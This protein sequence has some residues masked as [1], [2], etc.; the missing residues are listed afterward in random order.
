[1]NIITR[2]SDNTR[3]YFEHG[4]ITFKISWKIYKNE[5]CVMTHPCHKAATKWE[6]DMEIL[7]K[8]YYNT[9]VFE[10]QSISGSEVR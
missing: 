8:I 10:V 6:N 7:K 3:W 5:H 2:T 1:M 4:I 9:S